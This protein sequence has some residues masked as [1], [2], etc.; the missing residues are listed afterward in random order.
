MCNQP[1][2]RTW[3]SNWLAKSNFCKQMA[4]TNGTI[5]ETQPLAPGQGLRTYFYT[6]DGVVQAINGVDFS[7]ARGQVMGW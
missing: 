2:R 7:I 1:V 5:E 3:D 6:E 4:N